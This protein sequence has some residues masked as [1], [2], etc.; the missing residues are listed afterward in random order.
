MSR[1]GFNKKNAD[2]AAARRNRQATPIEQALQNLLR[3][4]HLIGIVH[5]TL[6]S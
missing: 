5:Y 6:Q 1:P 4:K 2:L 3:R